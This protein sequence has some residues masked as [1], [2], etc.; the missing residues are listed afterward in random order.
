MTTSE[1]MLWSTETYLGAMA[2]QFGT[3]MRAYAALRKELEGARWPVRK[4]GHQL[5]FIRPHDGQHRIVV[6]RTLPRRRRDCCVLRLIAPSS[7]I[8]FDET[9][10]CE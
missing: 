9:V 6:L 5:Y 8:K 1:I 4:A 2:D 3:K 7:V 10:F